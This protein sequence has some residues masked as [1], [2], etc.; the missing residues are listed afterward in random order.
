MATSCCQI[1]FFWRPCTNIYLLDNL[2]I[3]EVSIFFQSLGLDCLKNDPVRLFLETLCRLSL[4][5]QVFYSDKN[6][7]FERKIVKLSRRNI[8]AYLVIGE[9]PWGQKAASQQSITLLQI[10]VLNSMYSLYQTI[11]YSK[12][13]LEVIYKMISST[14]EV[15]VMLC[16]DFNRDIIY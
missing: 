12:N 15:W 14:S 1:F 4:V 10:Q 9:A 7:K 16:G 13:L 11:L 5:L 8:C 3:C 2:V 6:Q